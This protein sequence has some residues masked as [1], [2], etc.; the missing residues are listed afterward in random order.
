MEEEE[1][2][3]SVHNLKNI[4]R[5]NSMFFE[6]IF[7]QK[8]KTILL[9]IQFLSHAIMQ[10]PQTWNTLTKNLQEEKLKKFDLEQKNLEGIIQ[11]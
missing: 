7:F 1:L 4:S 5:N 2:L 11:R 10:C 8:N 6:D 3:S 9:F